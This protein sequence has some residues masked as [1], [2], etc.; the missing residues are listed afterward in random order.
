MC[1][2]LTNKNFMYFHMLNY[3]NT[4][5]LIGEKGQKEKFEMLENCLEQNDQKYNWKCQFRKNN[6]NLDT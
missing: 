6:I 1:G 3:V 5:L 4:Q 2:I